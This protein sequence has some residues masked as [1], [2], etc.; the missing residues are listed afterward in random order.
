MKPVPTDRIA[1]CV[2]GCRR[3]YKRDGTAS[4]IIC[5]KHWRLADK[6]LRRRSLRIRN[7]GR[8]LDWPERILDIEWRI[9]DRV[10]TLAFER[11]L[12]ISA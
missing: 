1:C 6:S 4:E 9:W 2:P 12:G 11:A 7:L 8:K 3:T 5:G 10:K